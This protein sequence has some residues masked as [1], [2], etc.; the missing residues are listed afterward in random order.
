MFSA[1]FLIPYIVFLII[2][3]LPLFFL[4]CCYGQFA[5]LS[6][7]SVWR[8][9][10]LF[11]G[12]YQLLHIRDPFGHTVLGPYKWPLTLKIDMRHGD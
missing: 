2:C 5:S 4:E 11:K 7:I 8:V 3:G 1:V 9:S 10:P 12:E 6:P